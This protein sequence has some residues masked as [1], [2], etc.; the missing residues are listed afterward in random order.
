MEAVVFVVF[1]SCLKFIEHGRIVYGH[2]R[3]SSDLTDMRSP[4]LRFN[5]DESP[6][7]IAMVG[8][9]TRMQS[10]PMDAYGA[11]FDYNIIKASRRWNYTFANSSRSYVRRLE[12]T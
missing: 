2:V 9:C 8:Q 11:L 5:M 10:S 4:W 3:Q 7:K 12:K 1:S 6:A